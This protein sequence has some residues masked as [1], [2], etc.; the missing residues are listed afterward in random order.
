MRDSF[1]SVPP[2]PIS[3]DTPLASTFSIP[4]ADPTF[5]SSPPDAGTRSVFSKRVESLESDNAITVDPNAPTPLPNDST[6]R[7]P[8]GEGSISELA[9]LHSTTPDLN[10]VP[11]QNLTGIGNAEAAEKVDKNILSASFSESLNLV[12]DVEGAQTH[13]TRS[14]SREK[15]RQ[16]GEKPEF[17]HEPGSIFGAAK[18]KTAVTDTE[19]SA[20]G[21]QAVHPRDING[22][23]V[24]EELFDDDHSR[25]ATA[26]VDTVPAP[27][28]HVNVN[29]I[30]T[31][32][33]S[34]P[35]SPSSSQPSASLLDSLTQRSPAIPI[36][37][38]QPSPFLPSPQ[39]S[40]ED[41]GV[42]L[43]ASPNFAQQNQAR[44]ESLTIDPGL[45]ER[46]TSLVTPIDREVPPVVEE[47]TIPHSETAPQLQ[48]ERPS[49]VEEDFFQQLDE[50]LELERHHR[51]SEI[52]EEDDSSMLPPLSTLPEDDPVFSFSPPRKSI[53]S[54]GSRAS[55]WSRPPRSL[56][57]RSQSQ[58]DYGSSSGEDMPSLTSLPD[59]SL[60]GRQG[61]DSSISLSEISSYN[62][63]A[64]TSSRS[65]KIDDTDFGMGLGLDFD[66]GPRAPR[67][68]HATIQSLCDDNELT[69]PYNV[70]ELLDGWRP[71]DASTM[72]FEPGSSAGTL[73]PVPCGNGSRRRSASEGECNADEWAAG[74][75]RPTTV[76]P[77]G[78][79]VR[80]HT[81]DY[82]S[83]SG[84]GN[85]AREW[86]GSGYGYQKGYRGG[87]E[88]GNGGT[89]G[90]RPNGGSGGSDGRRGRDDGGDSDRDRRTRPI[91][92]DSSST[93]SESETESEDDYGEDEPTFAAAVAPLQPA[94]SQR[95]DGRKG[96]YKPPMSQSEAPVTNVAQ[97]STGTTEDDD[98]PL[99]QRIPGALEAQKS[100]RRQAKSEREQ[101]KRERSVNPS[102]RPRTQEDIPPLP[103]TET[104]ER[105][106]TITLRPP[107]SSAPPSALTG[108]SSSQE[109]ALMAH[110]RAL[111]TN[112]VMPTRRA[113]AK[114]LG[115]GNAGFEIDDLTRRLL[116][117]QAQTDVEGSKLASNAAPPPKQPSRTSDELRTSDI[118]SSRAMNF[119]PVERSSAISS[120][121]AR[122][123]YTPISPR[124]EVQQFQQMPGQWAEVKEI[125]VRGL[126]PMRSF[127]GSS[128]NAPQVQLAPVPLPR[129]PISSRGKQSEESHP[130]EILARRPTSSRS[131][132]GE[133]PKNEEHVRNKLVKST[134]PSLESS[135]PPKSNRTS[136]E[137]AMRRPDVP[138]LPTPHM[139]SPASASASPM[140]TSFPG[141]MRSQM[142]IFIGD[143]QKF[144]VVDIG[145]ETNAKEILEMVQQ[146]G[147]LR[148]E[149]LVSGNWM[150][151]EICQDF[152]MGKLSITSCL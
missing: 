74:R 11:Y 116:R 8:S 103:S 51:S 14:T 126:R 22:A 97:N 113:R 55:S 17:V 73:K 71:L 143:Q 29:V 95:R 13:I 60:R 58:S 4:D 138:P 64:Y 7:P 38:R 32:S 57:S 86:G 12:V 43:S 92:M 117:V 125:P 46:I 67:A 65:L 99:A 146:Q 121:S 134:R 48:K 89:S 130:S 93:S 90:F 40:I 1:D 94:S 37:T 109:A 49:S 132:H 15:L 129:R 142:R 52:L 85:A 44:P 104:P 50:E 105:G 151:F 150:L 136:A 68:S 26:T 123:Q 124:S 84:G 100:I 6:Q 135:H 118:L 110:H 28:I 19:G 34:S 9:Y 145:P 83:R 148:R 112:R 69:I 131:K 45:P 3:K 98:V 107:L 54:D 102:S 128:N 18:L 96:V 80:S 27:E 77:L 87:A 127:H 139:L 82:N 152:G 72:G 16:G 39:F 42:V 23:A 24:N 31:S 10:P 111:E 137:D 78:G 120:S 5:A 62:G 140:R 47:E 66:E 114:T 122:T 41:L 91:A 88:Y 106:R 149:D 33:S 21:A 79:L 53:A 144:N 75:S 56:H 147:E 63:V 141:S 81:G 25:V 61:S 133:E 115:E 30:A 20:T 119:P 36:P 70:D 59:P 101:K 35:T 108:L 76:T 2:T